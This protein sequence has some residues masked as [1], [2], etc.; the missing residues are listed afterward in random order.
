MPGRPT[1][2][3]S[4]WSRAVTSTGPVARRALAKDI[5]VTPRADV[6]AIVDAANTTVA[7]ILNKVIGDP[8][9]P[10][11][12]TDIRRAPTRLFE[13][14]MGNL[15]AD[16]MREAHA[17]D[18]ATGLPDAEAAYTNSGGLRQDLLVHATVGHRADLPDHRRASCSPS[19][20]SAMP[21]SSRP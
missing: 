3:S 11:Q 12:V 16:A 7:P 8:T 21:R 2:S 20:P 13:S 6:K 9:Q 17:I 19:C 15:V 4:S 14:A 10:N 18:P 1:R 5:G